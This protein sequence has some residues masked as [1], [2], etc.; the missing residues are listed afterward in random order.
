MDGKNDIISKKTRIIELLD[1]KIGQMEKEAKLIKLENE[2]HIKVLL[3]IDNY[4]Y[5]YS[6]FY[7]QCICVIQFHNLM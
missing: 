1:R 4:I 3:I 6:I 7:E 2:Q 5:Y